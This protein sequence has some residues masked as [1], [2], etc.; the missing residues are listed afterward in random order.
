MKQNQVFMCYQIPQYQMWYKQINTWDN[1][2]RVPWWWSH[3][4]EE[5]KKGVFNAF[6]IYFSGLLSKILSKK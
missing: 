3:M 5:K 2:A 6:Y 1:N 4:L